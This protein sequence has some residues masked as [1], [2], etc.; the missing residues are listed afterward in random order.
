MTASDSEL[1][2]RYVAEKSEP[3][4]R[5]LIE[6]NLGLV[7][8]V[9]LR[10]AGFDGTAAEEVAQQVFILL[11]QKAG[12][13]TAHPSLTAWLFTA[14]RQIAMRH[15]RSELR[16]RAR[17]QKAHEMS[18]ALDPDSASPDWTSLRPVIDQ[19][20][21]ELEET[22]QRA[23]LWRFFEKQG[24]AGI[25][26]RL[27]VS[28][29]AARKRVTRAL[30]TLHGALS[31]R[32][33]TSTAAAIGL[34]LE[35][36][37]VATV[38]EGL[39]AK[40]LGS[41]AGTGAFVVVAVGPALA[42]SSR[43][44]LFTGTKLSLGLAGLVVACTVGYRVWRSSTSAS[45]EASAPAGISESA[46]RPAGDPM[47]RF[48]AA[49]QARAAKSA[50]DLEEARRRLREVL[51]RPPSSGEL[52]PKP[53]VETLALFQGQVGEAIPILVEAF[54]VE[55]LNTQIWALAGLQR[56]LWRWNE[57]DAGGPRRKAM[58][59]LRPLF[60]NVLADA[61]RPEAL[62]EMAMGILYP[63]KAHL[64]GL[65]D[66]QV[67]P[68]PEC[69]A[70]VERALQT[71][72]QKGDPYRFTIVDTLIGAGMLDPDTEQVFRRL[73]PLLE[74]P[75][76]RDRI[77]AAYAIAKSVIEKPAATKTVLLATLRV[78]NHE[79]RDYAVEGLAALGTNAVEV[80]P[81]LLEHARKAPSS[82]PWERERFLTAACRI[83]PELRAS[84]PGIDLRLRHEEQVQ[85]MATGEP[86]PTE[87][88]RTLVRWKAP[89][90]DESFQQWLRLNMLGSNAEEIRSQREK[91]IT[92]LERE[93]QSGTVEEKA[94]FQRAV[95]FVRT[96]PDT[97][98]KE[99]SVAPKPADMENL[100]LAAKEVL[101]DERN[102][103]EPEIDAALQQ[104]RAE[105]IRTGVFPVV[106][107]ESADALSK[108]LERIDPA[109]RKQWREQALKAKPELDR[110]MPN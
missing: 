30:D 11:S 96:M 40:V 62:R 108:I 42:L 34:A 65:P 83:Q 90:G 15:H 61:R 76:E 51:T 104:F 73:I 47:A 7:Y 22:D 57:D 23:V 13:L 68:D 86:L 1:L 38:P 31:R 18:H 110:L 77:L 66:S 102:T 54:R 17:D 37:A 70:E 93:M 45:L 64:A 56:V 20:I 91:L 27:G 21:A 36:N 101:A 8:S 60:G 19:A 52:P 107:R 79:Y 92:N 94:L 85:Q 5:E 50:A 89:E 58:A 48:R 35:G 46:S 53:L 6:R 39:A 32:G 74:A 63:R 16:R 33:V 59:E 105:K 67:H 80:V 44:T 88:F 75:A 10:N 2:Q 98:P 26:A 81:V 28:E 3:S 41:V 9:A 49:A 71:T 103:L 55:D 84:Y 78:P 43:A 106:T 100:I 87:F 25:G 99:A 82:M 95:E 72:I 24:Y 12:G 69:L 14:T 29:E 97:T 4:F 109:F